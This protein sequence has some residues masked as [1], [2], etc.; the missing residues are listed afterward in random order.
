ME[1]YN[2]RGIE[3]FKKGNVLISY[4]IGALGIALLLFGFV[5]LR[6]NSMVKARCTD[7]ASGIVQTITEESGNVEYIKA[8]FYADNVRYK[9]IAKH[10]R[11]KN[12]GSD[13]LFEEGMSVTVCYNPFDPDVNYI[14][15][16]NEEKGTKAML[17]GGII[18]VIGNIMMTTA[19]R[20]NRRKNE[21]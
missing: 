1:Q 18:F 11:P 7:K 13:S 17:A 4:L 20:K 15:G 8:D 12:A 5:G 2:K 10:H 16:A 21:F 3:Q 6:I 19:I 14:E 9:A